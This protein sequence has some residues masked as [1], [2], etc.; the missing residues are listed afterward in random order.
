MRRRPVGFSCLFFGLLLVGAS[1]LSAQTPSELP[2]TPRPQISSLDGTW[3][4]TLLVGTASLHLVLHVSKESD[5]SSKV[6]VDSV[7]QGVYAIEVTSVVR[8]ESVF[9]F[10]VVSAGAAFEGKI[11]P[12]HQTLSGSWSQSGAT[13]PLVFHHQS[14]TLATRKP[15]GAIADIEGLWQGRVESSGL[16]LR[17]QL[18]ISHNEQ[19][20]LTAALDSIDQAVTGIPAANVTREAATFHFE[21]PSVSSSYDG[22]LNAARNLISG[23]WTQTGAAQKLDFR[24][25]N[26]VLE[27][28][29][30]Q[31]PV[32]PYPY[33]EEA[34]TF[35]NARAEVILAGTFTLPRGPGPFPSAVLICDR[36]PHDRDEALAGHRPFLVLADYLTRKGIAVLRYDQRGVGGS[37][38]SSANSTSEDFAADA[39]S[40]LDYLKSRKEVDLQKIGLIGH[41]EGGLIAPLIAAHSSGVAWIVLLAGPGVPGEQNLLLQSEQIAR[42]SG[43][44]DEDIEKSLDFD[45]KAYALIRPEKN[46]AAR[47]AK[48]NELV[49]SS[50]MAASVSPAEIQAQIHSMSSP[51]FRYLLS[52]DPAVNLQQTKCPVLALNGAIDLQV[53]AQENLPAIR[54]AL[55]ES[56]NRDFQTI[57]LPGLNHLFQHAPTGTPREY[58]A[59]EETIAPEVLNTVSDWILKRSNP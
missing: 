58:G 52:F 47:E 4:G 32:K 24:R 15:V 19:K 14:S 36:G 21:I 22:E 5:G 35:P 6:T 46:R 57:E 59:I 42:A 51:S 33:R 27:L 18:H 30:P 48:L 23:T 13:L 49:Q 54:K 20:Q 11:S 44:A 1:S 56:G 34:V 31:N 40:A 38:G 9:S 2:S 45:K 25:S 43:M 39:E 55:E 28:R 3:S 12:D 17:L 26:Q 37:S 7:D 29:R 16:H 53:P 8:R 41:S 10:A 50:G